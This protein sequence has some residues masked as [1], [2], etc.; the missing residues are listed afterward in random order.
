MM[1][2]LVMSILFMNGC[3]KKIPLSYDQLEKGHYVYIE[4]ISGETINGDLVDKDKQVLAINQGNSEESEIINR[5]D[6]VHI[7]CKPPVYDE[8]NHL[9]SEQE[10]NSVKTNKNLWLFMIGGGVLS[11]GSS[12]FITA[13]ILHHTNDNAGG[14]ALWAPTIGATLLGTTF[15]GNKGYKS[16]RGHAI[17]KIK[18]N[19]KEE[20]IKEMARS[21][22]RRNKID[23]ELHE[24][25]K[26][27]EEQNEK[28]RQMLKKID[29]KKKKE[30]H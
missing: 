18:E 5:N 6:I 21:K 10:I 25:K 13:N 1:M 17:E 30:D 24:L 8:N 22:K 11:F 15:F 12:F 16:D 4:T 28:I 7:E 23:E 26:Q 20:A 2:I 14:S 19:R 27:R 3:A 29:K 9:I